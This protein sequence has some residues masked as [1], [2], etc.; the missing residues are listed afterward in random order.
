M[1]SQQSVIINYNPNFANGDA[2]DFTQPFNKQ[3]EIP[4]NSEVAFYQGQLQ[5]KT[6]VIPER[7]K[8]DIDY[9]EQLPT[10]DFRTKVTNGTYTAIDSANLLDKLGSDEIEIPKGS[11][12]Q[13]EFVEASVGNCST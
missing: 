9:V 8:I 11:Y 7:E 3:L 1:E 12:T 13:S 5:R 6:I 10:D 4:P 2:S